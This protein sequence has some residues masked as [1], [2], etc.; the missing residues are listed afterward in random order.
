MNVIVEI[1]ARD[2]SIH[3]THDAAGLTQA[4]DRKWSDQG[5]GL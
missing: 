1:G 4:V 5:A 3:R 2:A